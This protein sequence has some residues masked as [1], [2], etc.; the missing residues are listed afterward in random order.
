MEVRDDG[1]K[2]TFESSSGGYFFFFKERGR[3][4]DDAVERD[5]IPNQES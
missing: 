4:K 2:C 3:P 1:A 5:E